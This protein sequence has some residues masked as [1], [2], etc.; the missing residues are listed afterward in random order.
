MSKPVTVFLRKNKDLN[1]H[2]YLFDNGNILIEDCDDNGKISA[3][4]LMPKD[5]L[6]EWMR[7]VI[8]GN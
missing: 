6:I 1:N 2:T 8:S 4:L 7:I 5:A 3:R